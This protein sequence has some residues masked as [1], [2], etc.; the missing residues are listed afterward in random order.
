[1]GVKVTVEHKIVVNGEEYHSLEEMPQELRQAY[2]RAMASSHGAAG[3]ALRGASIVFQGKQ[4]ASPEQMPVE[5]RKLYDLAMAA[6]TPAR[7]SSRDAEAGEHGARIVE[8][9]GVFVVRP[10]AGATLD[11]EA[12]PYRY[13]VKLTLGR[14]GLAILAALLLLI[15]LYA[16][17]GP[18]NF[19]R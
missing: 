12:Q 1:M 13:S 10:H 17:S 2:A 19:P 15:F 5:E 6:A 3:L 7:A 14:R 11:V 8:T 9:D 4:Y 18:S 16:L